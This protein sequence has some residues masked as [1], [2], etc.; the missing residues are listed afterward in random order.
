M[1]KQAISALLAA[2][3]LAGLLAGALMLRC[4]KEL[5]QPDAT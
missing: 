3:V 2:S 5:N 4:R 1:K